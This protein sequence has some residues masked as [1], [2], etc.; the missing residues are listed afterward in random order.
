MSYT[1]CRYARR[2]PELWAQLPDDGARQRV[3]NALANGRLEG[4]EPDREF[5]ADFV[6]K[7]RGDLTGE[8]YRARVLARAQA[9]ADARLGRHAAAG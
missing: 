6:A 5:V 4:M 1:P 2:W 8:Q 3:T 9:E 7:V